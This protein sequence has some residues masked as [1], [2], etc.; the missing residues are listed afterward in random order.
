[1]TDD[2]GRWRMVRYRRG[3]SGRSRVAT[4]PFR[5]S[6]A[7]IAMLAAL[8]L[9]FTADT[10]QAYIGPGAGIAIGTTLIASLLSF[11]SVLMALVLWP[12]RCAAR[13]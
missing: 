13:R 8:C 10:A 11:F 12:I 9:L 2:I 5:L 1:M 4:A 7:R 6:A 3:H